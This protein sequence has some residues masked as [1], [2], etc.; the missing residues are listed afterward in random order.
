MLPHEVGEVFSFFADPLNLEAITPPWLRFRIL[1]APARLE[2][3][4]RLRY[5]LTLHGVP[6]RWLTEI[7]RWQRPRTFT[8]LQLRGPYLLW[9]HTHRFRAVR[10]G[11]EVYDHVAYRVPGGPLAPRAYVRRSV[12]EIFDYRARELPALVAA[13]VA[14]TQ[15][16]P[17]E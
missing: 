2:R 1:E 13:R 3:G 8:D 16:L 17:N 6:V 11:T 15:A 4:S 10:G 7:T 12:E 14:A 5:R 9:E